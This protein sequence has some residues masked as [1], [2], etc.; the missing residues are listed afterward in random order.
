MTDAANADGPE[1]GPPQI[2]LV[3]PPAFEPEEFAPLLERVLDSVPVACLR[4]SM[5][6]TDETAVA[7]AADALR[8]IAHARDV[9]IVIAQH[10]Q[11]VQPLG[12]DGVHFDDG[13]RKVRRA[14]EVLGG[15]AIVGAF[16]GAS[17]HAGMTAGETGADYVAFGPVGET[18]L[19]DGS[20]APRDLFEFWSEAIEVPVVAEGAL[21][22]ALAADMAAI[23]DF[24]A[25]GEE[26]WRT[27][28][29]VAELRAYRA[30]L[31]NRG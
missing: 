19:G 12:L 16:C 25:L 17:R 2:Y 9:A 14:R 31:E 27:D 3:T 1:A 26:I 8:A 15:D 22:R 18:A 21:S 11:L 20:R 29:P 24:V 4:L 6:S 13:A 30:A 7:R 10:L 5:A 28:D 23:T